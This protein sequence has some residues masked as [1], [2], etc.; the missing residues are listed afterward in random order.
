MKKKPTK[1]RCSCCD[2]LKNEKTNIV[3]K[4]WNRK[5]RPEKSPIVGICRGCHFAMKAA[6]I[7][8]VQLFLDLLQKKLGMFVFYSEWVTKKELKELKK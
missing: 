4:A 7:D 1:Y 5:G 8:R 2:E 6:G 3:F